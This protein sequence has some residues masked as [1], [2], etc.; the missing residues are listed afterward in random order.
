MFVQQSIWVISGENRAFS[1]IGQQRDK[2]SRTGK[3]A[4]QLAGSAVEGSLDLDFDLLGF[5]LLSG[6][7]AWSLSR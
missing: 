3:R 4:I 1:I 7:G 2:M 6:N 5:V